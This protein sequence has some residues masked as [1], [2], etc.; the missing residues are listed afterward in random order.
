M[1]ARTALLHS[2]AVAS[3]SLAGC[4]LAY[5]P[6]STHDAGPTGDAS[7]VEC[8][9][10][11][12]PPWGCFIEYGNHVCG[13]VETPAECVDGAWRCPGG[14]GECWCSGLEVHGPFC[15]CTPTGWSC[16]PEIDAGVADAGAVCPADPTAAV[17]SACSHEGQSC[18][19]CPGP[20]SFCQLLICQGGVW[21]SVEVLPDCQPTFD[22]GPTSCVRSSEYCVHTLS[23]I[24]G[25]PDDYRCQ[26]M[27]AGC[28]SCDCLATT[29]GPWGPSCTDDGAGAVTLVQGGG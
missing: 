16:P 29:G 10:G 28:S 13:D 25:V 14:G 21:Q 19:D 22:C 24:G 3:L 18:G 26:P 1:Q 5:N 15:V 6:P 9:P 2:L 8:H 11:D 4:G 27:P 23:D 12:P 17:G 7:P 20:C